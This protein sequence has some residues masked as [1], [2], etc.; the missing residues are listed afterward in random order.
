MGLPRATFPETSESKE[1]FNL[2]ALPQEEKQKI[3]ETVPAEE[4]A[5]A[6]DSGNKVEMC[7]FYIFF[8][9]NVYSICRQIYGSDNIVA[10]II[11]FFNRYLVF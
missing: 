8:P 2:S 3:L 5:I 10:V 11:F 6:P 1:S 9:F 4:K 7:H